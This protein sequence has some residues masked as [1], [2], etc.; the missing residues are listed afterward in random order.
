[1]LMVIWVLMLLTVISA[2][3]CYTMRTRVNI[4]RNLKASTEAYYHAVAGV[5]QAV[6]EILKKEYSP[7]GSGGSDAADAEGDAVKWRL[8]ADLP[9]VSFGSGAYAVRIQNESGR[10]DINRAGKKLLLAVLEGLTPDEEKRQII[11]DSILDWRDAN[12]L[13][14][15][16][17][18]EDDYYQGLDPPYDCKDGDFD[19]IE[20]L[21][22]VRG[23]TPELFYGGLD[24]ITTVLPVKRRKRGPDREALKEHNFDKININAAP[25]EL[26]ANLPGM[27]PELVEEIEAFR[28]EDRFRSPA[29]L[30]EIVGA[31]V[32]GRISPYL[33]MDT[34]SYYTI[35]SEGRVDGS[36]A[37][38]GVEALVAVSPEAEKK[39]RIV[40]WR[41][42][43]RPES[44]MGF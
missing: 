3:F 23:V 30:R 5:H 13:H 15:A 32:Y 34:L 19:S 16:N 6:A 10:I 24:E 25:P 26:W 17:G 31:E 8:N 40:K 12:K 27:T 29:E 33:S 28:E 1:M 4:T 22:R 11:A 43:S 44:G 41:D 21:L 9:P 18:A 7:G 20:E 38:Q 35:F 36:A 14:R 42:R 39:Y 2:E 37:R